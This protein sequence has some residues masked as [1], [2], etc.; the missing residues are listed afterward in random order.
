MAKPLSSEEIRKELA[1]IQEQLERL[2]K[3]PLK[4]VHNDE[5]GF[6]IVAEDEI[7]ISNCMELVFLI[8][9]YGFV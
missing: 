5:F 7:P 1:F 9:R 3:F 4:A 2:S 6:H 8:C